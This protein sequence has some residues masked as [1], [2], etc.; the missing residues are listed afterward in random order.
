MRNFCLL[1]CSQLT[2][3][4]RAQK[5]LF[6]VSYELMAAILTKSWNLRVICI[7]HIVTSKRR[8]CFVMIKNIVHGLIEQSC[9]FYNSS[10]S[11]NERIKL[12]LSTRLPV[13]DIKA[14]YSLV[15][16][17][18]LA[19][20]LF[21]T[22]NFILLWLLF[23]LA[24]VKNTVELLRLRIFYYLNEYSRDQLYHWVTKMFTLSL[25]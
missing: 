22:I 24:I 25:W 23:S 10:N 5:Q 21:H 19:S 2:L 15:R 12:F 17:K 14:S 11:L 3:V 8:R 13:V 20:W 1:C 7:L 18:C 4:I 16:T 9:C 6:S